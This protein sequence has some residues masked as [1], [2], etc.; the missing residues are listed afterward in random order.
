MNKID[1]YLKKELPDHYINPPKESGEPPVKS[2]D[3]LCDLYR[4]KYGSFGGVEFYLYEEETIIPFTKA[5]NKL[6]KAQGN[7]TKV[8]I[9]LLRSNIDALTPLIAVDGEI[10]SR[11]VYPDLASMR[12]GSNS[13]SRGGDGHHTH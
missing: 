13:I 4:N 8:D 11:G 1:I 9:R 7:D 3:E 6:F 12:G 5:L 2:I 10:V